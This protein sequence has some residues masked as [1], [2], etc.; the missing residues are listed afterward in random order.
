MEFMLSIIMN[1]LLL[2]LAEWVIKWQMFKIQSKYKNYWSR[3]MLIEADIKET[4]INHKFVI[5]VEVE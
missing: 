2:A 4:L 1:V 5:W 3:E